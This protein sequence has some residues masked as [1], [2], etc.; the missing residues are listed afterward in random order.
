MGD[1]PKLILEDILIRK[2]I[3]KSFPRAGISDIKISRRSD[4]VKIE[5]KAAKAGVVLGKGGAEVAAHRK[6]LESEYGKRFV[7]HV[8]E[9]KNP[10]GNAKLIAASLSSQ[11]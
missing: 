3:E 8:A 10:E 1:Y 6:M 11:I 2:Q 5:I 4:N 9:Q 7:I